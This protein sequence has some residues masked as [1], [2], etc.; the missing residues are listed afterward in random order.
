MFV[1]Y[2]N[3]SNISNDAYN[4]AD[5]AECQISSPSFCQ[6]EERNSDLELPNNQTPARNG[7]LQEI[8]DP[9]PSSLVIPISVRR[10]CIG[11]K[12]CMLSLMF[13]QYPQFFYALTYELL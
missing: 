7:T 12:L 6:Q 5:K 2:L 4:I 13:A 11:V 3:W 1:C 8:P 9:D 10:H